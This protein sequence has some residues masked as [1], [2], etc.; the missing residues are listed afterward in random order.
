MIFKK[1]KVKVKEDRKVVQELVT[2]TCMDILHRLVNELVDVY[3]ILSNQLLNAL[4]LNLRDI[5][6]SKDNAEK[7]KRVAKLIDEFLSKC[8]S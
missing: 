5:K 4:E 2:L 7:L 3:Q 6:I 1:S 8:I